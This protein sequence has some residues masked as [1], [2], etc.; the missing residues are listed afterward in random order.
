MVD[1]SLYG[2]EATRRPAEAVWGPAPS[3]LD[4]PGKTRRRARFSSF[5]GIDD[6]APE[7][8][9]ELELAGSGD[10]IDG[11]LGIVSSA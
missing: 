4:L 3:T 5:D 11:G 7:L 6:Q 8:E 1:L 9:L 10:A 2:D